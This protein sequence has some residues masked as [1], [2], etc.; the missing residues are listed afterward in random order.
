MTVSSPDRRS[1]IERDVLEKLVR[2]QRDWPRRSVEVAGHS[3]IYRRN[4]VDRSRPPVVF[5]PGIQGGGDLLF[6][7]AMALGG[8]VD[9]VTVDAPSITDAQEMTRGFADFL[10][11]LGLERVSVIGSSLG[12]YLAQGFA[13]SHPNRIEQLIVA[14][15]FFDVRPFLAQSPP[16]SVF[17]AKD[18][19]AIVK[20]NLAG[21]PGDASDD[22]GH[23]RLKAV[24]QAL[25][26][27][28]QPFDGYKSRLL[29]MMAAPPLAPPALSPA[30]VMVLDDDADPLLPPA[31]RDPV[32]AR[33]AGSEQHRIE[34]GGH[35]P[36]V[37]R[38]AEFGRLVR[39]RFDVA[40]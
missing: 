6:D 20:A 2:F 25:V 4:Q 8:M 9:V 31:M 3:W 13:L 24:V 29:L 30:Q 18:A 26:G 5:L 32:R 17:E 38:P 28:L 7:G 39:A 1:A 27:P 36:S 14:N 15:G 19:A 16:I 37:Q 11:A 22:D 23:I 40:T 12:G 34:G 35:L 10:S 33:F 21:I